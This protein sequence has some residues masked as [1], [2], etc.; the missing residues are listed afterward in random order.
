MMR[1]IQTKSRANPLQK[2]V[3]EGT[4]NRE[5]PDEE[6]TGAQSKGRLV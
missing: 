6:Q 3:L 5:I 1:A 2:D 4:S